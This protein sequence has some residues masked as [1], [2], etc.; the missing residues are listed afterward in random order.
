[1]L[2]V[3]WCLFLLVSR[4]EDYGYIFKEK[5]SG[6]VTNQGM[7]LYMYLNLGNDST[8]LRHVAYYG[9]WN[10][11]VAF[12]GN[13]RPVI[14]VLNARPSS[15][16]GTWGLLSAVYDAAPLLNESQLTV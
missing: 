11:K 16:C 13:K 2:N 9:I 5:K 7:F 4:A 14:I 10:A 1:M 8:L 6:C 15:G 3:W 12:G